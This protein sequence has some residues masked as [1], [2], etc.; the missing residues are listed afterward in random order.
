[1]L[2]AAALVAY[3]MLSRTVLPKD[4]RPPLGVLLRIDLTSLGVNHA[5]PGGVA[6]AAALRYRLLT[7]FGV[8]GSD[9]V[10]GAVAQSA[11]SALVLN[12]MIWVT[13]LVAVPVYGTRP[14]FGLVVVVGAAVFTLVA[15]VVLALTRGHGRTARLVRRIAS[16]LPRVTPDQAERQVGRIT[17]NLRAFTSDRRLLG[18]AA[19]WS[20]ANWML[21]AASLWVF[22]A[23]FGYRIEPVG[24][25]VAFGVANVLAALPVTPG[26]LGIV[27]GTL[28]PM[29][30]VVGAPHEAALLAV[31]SWRLVNFWLPLPVAGLTYLSLRARLAEEPLPVLGYG[32]HPQP[33]G[34]RR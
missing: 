6:V 13:L 27:E 33:A 22:L 24:L 9:A 26:G 16:V 5:F 28:V 15:A 29:L 3:S 1:A 23:A 8:R 4:N 25:L 10:F 7:A 34:A 21:D 19:G 11:G 18:R 14:L 2:E 30:V 20:S 12:G 32:G 17:E 31:L